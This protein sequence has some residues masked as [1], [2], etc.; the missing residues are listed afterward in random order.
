MG[1]A[2]SVAP[3]QPAF[4]FV[5]VEV[6]GTAREL[7]IDE[8]AYLETGFDGADGNRPYIKVEYGQ[9]DGW[10]ELS[11]FLHRSKLPAGTPVSPAPRRRPMDMLE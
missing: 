7:S 10:G 6:D 9:R 5:Y 11:G 3:G 1:P 4:P 2:V 8:R